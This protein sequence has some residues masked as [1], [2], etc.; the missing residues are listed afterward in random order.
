MSY[1]LEA[2]KKAEDERRREGA[3]VLPQ[4]HGYP[5]VIAKRRPLWLGRAFGSLLVLFILAVGIYKYRS[6][7]FRISVPESSDALETHHSEPSA[8][9]GA[10]VE[11]TP[12][13]DTEKI[14]RPVA[15][16]SDRKKIRLQLPSE[17]LHGGQPNKIVPEKKHDSPPSLQELPP[18]IRA[19]LPE[20][21]IAGHTYSEDPRKRMI[22]INGKIL[23]EGEKIDLT[24]QLLEITWEGVIIES[25]GV[26]FQ[27]KI[28]KTE[29]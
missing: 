22:I 14:R 10:A 16:K 8:P 2:L 25:R 29:Q 11:P 27:T 20:L 6:L 23:K 19:G 7:P 3:P 17:H 24:S 18:G 12:G 13:I 1:I 26:R 5:A 9:P 21:K 15:I 28:S 4:P